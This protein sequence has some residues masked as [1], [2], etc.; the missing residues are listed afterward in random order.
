MKPPPGFL[1]ER[2]P[3]RHSFRYGTGLCA[4]SGDGINSTILTLVKNYKGVNLPDTINVNPH[5]GSFDKETGAI[6]APMSIIDKLKLT[7]T[8]S[9]LSTVWET[10]KHRAMKIQWM[11]IFTSFPEKLDSVDDTTSQTALDI[12]ELTKDATQEDI[13]PTFTGTSLPVQG[14]SETTHP[15]TTANFTEVFGTLNLTTDL[16]QESVAWNS[17]T[18][19]NAVKYYT[20]KGAIRSMTGQMRTITLSE[21]NPT[22]TVHINKFVPRAIRRIVPYSYFGILIHIPTESDHMQ[23]YYSTAVSSA[24]P[25]IGVKLITHY[26]EW[27]SDH[28]QE[29]M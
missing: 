16:I 26:N 7:I 8:F 14:A 19:F 2:Y 4:G 5:H 23:V 21:T 17:S 15:V 3:L 28:L 20:N 25:H 12:L 27:N 11:P 6:C 18:F 1:A 10:D 24:L 22:K 29:M 9:L 13:T